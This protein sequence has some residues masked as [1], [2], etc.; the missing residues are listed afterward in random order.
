MRG[1]IEKGKLKPKNKQQWQQT[2]QSLNGKEV[3]IDIKK[4]KNTRTQ[5]QNR[6]MHKLFREISQQMN[7]Q[8]LTLQQVLRSDVETMMTPKLVKE[9][10]WKPVQKA[11]YGKESTTQ[12]TT[13]EVDKVFDVINK[14]LGKHGIHVPFPSIETLMDND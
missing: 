12:L 3:T 11:M 6:A 1:Q 2:L 7:E 14:H 8:G 10:I 9:I 4:H 13:D 5:R